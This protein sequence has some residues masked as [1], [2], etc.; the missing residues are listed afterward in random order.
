LLPVGEGS[1]RQGIANVVHISTARGWWGG[2]RQVWLLVRGLQ[3]LGVTQTVATVAG[4]A[5]AGRLTE[6]A[7]PQVQLHA[8]PFHPVNLLRLVAALRSI[9]GTIV[10]SHTSPALTLA[11]V[12]RRLAPSCRLVHTRRVAF[13]A[14]RSRKYRNAADCYVAISQA[15]ANCLVEAGVDESRLRTIASAVDIKPLDVAAAAAEIERSPSRPVIGCVGR[16][17][18]EKGHVYLLAAWTEVVRVRPYARLVMVGSGPAEPELRAMASR[19]PDGSVIFTGYR[20]DSAAWLKT[21]DIYVQPSLSEGLGTTVLDA[22]ACRLPVIASRVGGL[23]EVVE[24]GSSGILVPP[25]QPA[26]LADAILQLLTNSEKAAS[27]GQAGRRRVEESF[28]CDRMIEAYLGV[29]Q[30]LQGRGTA[31]GQ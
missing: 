28:T 8:L 26:L 31:P 25:E 22:M 24:D 3:A 4:S 17:S 10:H 18:R 19:F 21:F 23:C 20:D 7:V 30:E 29:Y 15:V 5:L 6:L 1:D 27:M 13:A 2:E 11:A 14:R 12:A 16:F 9:P